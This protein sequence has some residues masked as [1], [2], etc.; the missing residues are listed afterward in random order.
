MFGSSDVIRDTDRHFIIFVV[1][2]V[3]KSAVLWTVL[4]KLNNAPFYIT[5]VG[6]TLSNNIQFTIIICIHKFLSKDYII[7]AVCGYTRK[8]CYNTLL[9]ILLN[10][11]K[12]ENLFEA[13]FFFGH[14]SFPLLS[15]ENGSLFIRVKEDIWAVPDRFAP[16]PPNYSL[17]L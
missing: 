1:R 4:I 16:T 9:Q 2:S 7:R 10:S 5:V 11:A 14:N 12:N 13:F 6:L 17:F 3:G 15:L 8:T